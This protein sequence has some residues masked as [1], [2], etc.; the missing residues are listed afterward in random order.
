MKNRNAHKIR[1]LRKG[2]GE[3]CRTIR[4]EALR[5]EPEAFGSTYEKES[6]RDAAAFED[7]VI[8]GCIFGAFSAKRIV[9]MA[10]FY[11]ESGEKF[12]HKGVLWGMY[13]NR[14]FR[15]F[16][17]GSDL[18]SAVLD[19]AKEVVDLVSL[20]VA[21][22]NTLAMALYRK[23]GFQTYGVEARALKIQERYVSETLM[24]RDLS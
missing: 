8:A 14:D 23:M 4:L 24:V 20:A 7:R 21:T 10:G 16:G 15:S 18:V 11:Q 5:H 19:H 3:N 2:D 12:E 9:G 1:R 6:E 17:I 22:E 13:V